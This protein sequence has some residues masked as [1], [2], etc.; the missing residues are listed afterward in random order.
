MGAGL[1]TAQGRC[2]VL[3]QGQAGWLWCG[4]SALP[5]P[6][7]KAGYPRAELAQPVPRPCYPSRLPPAWLPS[8]T[9]SLPST[10]R[11]LSQLSQGWL[12]SSSRGAAVTSPSPA[13]PLTLAAQLG[14]TL[15]HLPHPC[16]SWPCQ[17][18]A[19]GFHPFSPPWPATPQCDCPIAQPQSASIT[20]AFPSPSLMGFCTPTAGTGD[21]RHRSR[22]PALG[23][24]GRHLASRSQLL[25]PA[26]PSSRLARQFSL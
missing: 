19:S 18:G 21:M 6:C 23:D 15:G 11:L 8:L 12:G 5:W 7:S 24:A 25:P 14:L 22:R 17:A 16:S 2:V 1:G 26:E 4:G 13:R 10:H 20:P 9:P 3:P